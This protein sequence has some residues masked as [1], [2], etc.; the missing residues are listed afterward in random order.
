MKNN[1]EE[2]FVKHILENFYKNKH[3][4][5][6]V[7]EKPDL[8][9]EKLSVGIEVTM[10]IPEKEQNMNNLANKLMYEKNNLRKINGA[11]SKIQQNGGSLT[12]I[13]LDN[14]STKNISKGEIFNKNQYDIASVSF[15]KWQTFTNI[16]DRL[17]DKLKKLNTPNQYK[18]FKNQYLFIIDQNLKP[19]EEHLDEIMKNFDRLQNS[20]IKKFNYIFLYL[21]N[22][23]NPLYEF[24]MIDKTYKTHYVPETII[25]KASN[26]I[27]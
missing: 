2:H 23:S 10:A 9:D 3:Y 20:A 11:I 24:N 8:Q 13:N 22:T 6:E 26:F 27:K 25:E 14:N 5:F 16:Y 17:E 21:D 1:S 19:S 15:C 7:K 18:D 12:K 4:N